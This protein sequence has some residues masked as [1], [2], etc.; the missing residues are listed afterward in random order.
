MSLHVH[1][2]SLRRSVHARKGREYTTAMKAAWIERYGTPDGLQVRDVPTPIP[3]PG[4]VLVR[5]QAVS[6]NDWDWA[7]LQASRPAER[8][9]NR[10]TTGGPVRIL[11]CDVAGR[12][13]AVGAG[14]RALQP[15][16]PVYGDLSGSGF[17]GLAEYVCAPEASL[18]RKPPAMTFEQAAAIPQAA[19]LAIQGLVDVGGIRPGQ[20]LLLNGAGGGVGTFALQL[21]RLYDAEVT[22]VD[23]AGK[24]DRL[25]AMG[26]QHVVDHRTQDFTAQG[27]RYDLIL[28]VKTNRPPLAYTRALKP[29]G[30]YATVGGEIPRLLQTFLLGPFVSRLSGKHLRVV[31]LKPNKDLARVN[32]LFEAGR[33]VPVI[34][35]TYSFPDVREAF[36]RFGTGDHQGKVVVTLT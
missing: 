30:V 6:V 17:G 20:Q 36:R 13:E 16:D 35:G 32:E 21:A 1:D 31:V 28:D 15:G 10:L 34:D 11:G 2:Q 5:V 25:R 7:L 33:L 18:A 22:V 19:M 27:R 14:V 8:F 26:A 9:F 24:L 3:R 12:V 4:E 29:E 23:K